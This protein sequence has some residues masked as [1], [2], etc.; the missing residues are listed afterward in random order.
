LFSSFI[1]LILI[2]DLFVFKFILLKIPST[3]SSF[4]N[5]LIYFNNGGKHDDQVDA[6]SQFFNYY[7]ENNRILDINKLP[8]IFI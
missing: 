5:E 7:Y 2:V 6:L 1:K 3:S 8:I 4:E